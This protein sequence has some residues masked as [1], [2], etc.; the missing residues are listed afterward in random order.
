MVKTGSFSSVVKDVSTFEF[1]STPEYGACLEAF[2]KWHREYLGVTQAMYD[3]TF[4]DLDLVALMYYSYGTLYNFF[5]GFDIIMV[6]EF[7]KETP[8]FRPL[9]Y[10][11]PSES[12]AKALRPV[13]V[14]GSYKDRKDAEIAGF[15]KAFEILKEGIAPL[16]SSSE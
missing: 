15:V 16:R 5:D 14:S 7:N 1:V 9:I 10:M 4:H 6:L 8:E 11:M 12:S 13:E 2:K 3:S